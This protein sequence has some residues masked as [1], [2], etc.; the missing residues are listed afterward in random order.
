MGSPPN[1]PESFWAR[2]DQSG[3]CWNWTGNTNGR[4]GRVEW[5]GRTVGTHRL[6]YELTI[7]TT[8]PDGQFVLHSCDN[9]LCCNPDHL[10]LGDHAEN[11]RDRTE[12]RRTFG[13]TAT[14]CK[15]GHE[16]DEEN[17]YIT[18]IGGR[19]CRACRR[20]AERA[21]YWRRK[22]AS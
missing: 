21:R 12:R 15:H 2:V 5:K 22:D 1:T 11:M 16:F 19:A 10:R 9:P 6:A 14:H 3:E 17:T 4:Y 7:G 8:I 18:T 13:Q 20:E